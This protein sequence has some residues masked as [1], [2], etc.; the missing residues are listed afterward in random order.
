MAIDL[1][2]ESLIYQLI[3]RRLKEPEDQLITT[4]II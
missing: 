2:N 4:I 3:S 1:Q